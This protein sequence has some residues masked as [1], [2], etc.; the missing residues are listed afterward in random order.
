MSKSPQPKLVYHILV[1]ELSMHPALT[2]QP[3]QRIP[4]PLHLPLTANTNHWH[5]SMDS[6]AKRVAWNIG[7]VYVKRPSRTTRGSL[8]SVD[9]HAFVIIFNQNKLDEA[10]IKGGFLDGILGD[11]VSVKANVSST[12]PQHVDHG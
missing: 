2:F 1:L 4:E 11:R 10:G 9:E 7:T 5:S 3:R 8:V 12:T 6:R